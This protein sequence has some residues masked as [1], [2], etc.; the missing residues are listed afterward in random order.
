MLKRHVATDVC[1]VGGGTEW[2]SGLR[3]WKDRE[4]LLETGRGRAAGEVHR[5]GDWH[6][7]GKVPAH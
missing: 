1:T 4:G 7:I 6:R 3:L 5:D 2:V